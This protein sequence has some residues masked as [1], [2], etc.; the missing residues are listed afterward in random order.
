MKNKKLILSLIG[1]SLLFGGVATVKSPVEAA[2]T[3]IM[4]KAKEPDLNGNEIEDYTKVRGH[5]D[6]HPIYPVNRLGVFVSSPDTVL[7]AAVKNACSAWEPAFHFD[8]LGYVKPGDRLPNNHDHYYVD[9]DA[10]SIPT[11]N[12]DE[13]G[14]IGQ[15]A[16]PN[17]MRN[18]WILDKFRR[19]DIDMSKISFYHSK[20]ENTV[21][22]E[23]G[24]VIG[25]KHSNNSSS[26][27][28]PD[29]VDG[30]VQTV[31]PEDIALVERLYDGKNYT[32]YANKKNPLRSSRSSKGAS[33]DTS[34]SLYIGQLN[35]K[36][37]YHRLLVE[38]CFY[39]IDDNDKVLA[40]AYQ[41]YLDHYILHNGR[42]ISSHTRLHNGVYKAVIRLYFTGISPSSSRRD[43]S[44]MISKGDYDKDDTVD[45]DQ[46]LSYY[47]HLKVNAGSTRTPKYTFNVKF[48]MHGHYLTI[49][50]DD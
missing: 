9:V 5:D 20:L 1:I 27:M 40:N 30:Q 21:I 43:A 11:P 37:I 26:L 7:Q 47:N 41:Y 35:A 6:N 34:K 23:L 15:T 12:I 42:R 39:L 32:T 18:G 25:L 13:G 29:N 24:H 36:G 10:D 17:H 14:P 19:V 50:N 28:Y 31:R 45:E 33:Y 48:R 46:G 8:Y 38:P 22:H 44:M 2:N 4:Q 49:I 16:F 3:V